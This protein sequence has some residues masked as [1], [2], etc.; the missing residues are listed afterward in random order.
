MCYTN[1]VLNCFACVVLMV[2]ETMVVELMVELM[3]FCSGFACCVSAVMRYV[4]GLFNVFFCAD[5]AAYHLHFV[6]SICFMFWRVFSIGLHVL[7]RPPF[8]LHVISRP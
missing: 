2:V 3:V 5:V 7:P 4:G 1:R 8:A 6:F